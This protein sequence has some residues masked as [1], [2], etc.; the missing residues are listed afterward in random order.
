MIIG[1]SQRVRTVCE[2]DTLK[3]EDLFSIDIDVATQRLA[4]REH[5]MA[6]HLQSGGTAIVEPGNDVQNTLFDAFVGIRLQPDT[7]IQQE[8]DL[9]H[10]KTTIPS[11]SVPIRDDLRP[12]GK[13]CSTIRIFPVDVPG[14]HEL[15]DCNED[16]DADTNYFCETTICIADDDGRFSSKFL[17]SELLIKIFQTHLGLHL[18]KKRSQLM[19]VWVQ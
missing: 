3:G 10:L 2:C 14:R 19:R 5:P 17:P 18:W 7:P 4:E 16:E 12:E 13:E 9:E 11:L 8:F 15:F 1:F 6:F